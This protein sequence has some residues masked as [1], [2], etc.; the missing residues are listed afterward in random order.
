MN[1]MPARLAQCPWQRG[2][3]GFAASLVTLGDLPAVTSRMGPVPVV[4]Q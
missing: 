2:G 3:W 4:S 1:R